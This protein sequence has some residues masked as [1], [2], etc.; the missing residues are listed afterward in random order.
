MKLVRSPLARIRVRAGYGSAGAA[1]AHLPC[2]RGYLLEL[3]QGRG[4]P[5][6]RLTSALAKLYGVGEDQITHAARNAQR[7]LHRREL[8]R[9]RLTGS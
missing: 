9:L 4:F 5:S 3:E 2:G 1:A 8:E 6:A 7:N